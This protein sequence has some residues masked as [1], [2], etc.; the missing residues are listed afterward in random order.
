MNR[1]HASRGGRG[2]ALGLGIA[3]A[4]VSTITGSSTALVGLLAAFVLGAIFP[5]AALAVGALV[6][7]PEA[8]VAVA[9]G[10]AD[11]VGLAA[12]ALVAGAVAVACS[13][14]LAGAGGLARRTLDRAARADRGHPSMTASTKRSSWRRLR[15]S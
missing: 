11:S 7:L 12:V 1:D 5:E 2:L 15:H 14:L 13:A 6:I 8:A 3:F 9:R 4:A 10:A